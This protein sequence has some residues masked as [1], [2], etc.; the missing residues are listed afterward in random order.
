MNLYTGDTLSSG[1]RVRRRVRARVQEGDHRWYPPASCW[2]YFLHTMV[3]II[4]SLCVSNFS[5]TG[6]CGAFQLDIFSVCKNVLV[7]FRFFIGGDTL[8][9]KVPRLQFAPF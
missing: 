2:G 5:I 9:T 3:L 7:L 6:T 4:G 8:P 1:G